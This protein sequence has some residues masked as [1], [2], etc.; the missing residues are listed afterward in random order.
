MKIKNENLILCLTLATKKSVQK[1]LKNK[2]SIVDF[3]IHHR[4]DT[5]N[6]VKYENS[7]RGIINFNTTLAQ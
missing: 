7:K 1:G 6:V 4:V 5:E 2:L 3:S